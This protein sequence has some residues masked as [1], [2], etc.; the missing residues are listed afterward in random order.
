MT[1]HPRKKPFTLTIDLLGDWRPLAAAPPPARSDHDWRYFGTVTIHGVS[2]ALAWKAGGYGMAV[3][4]GPV[5]P[6]G[7]WKRIRINEI[8][9]F[10]SPPGRELAPRRRPSERWGSHFLSGA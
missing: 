8:M 7:L 2:G 10:E 9:E 5:R 3:G 1:R 4:D 6:L